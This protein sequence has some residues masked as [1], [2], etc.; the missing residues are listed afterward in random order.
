MAAQHPEV[1]PGQAGQERR[2]V[3][4]RSPAVV[5]IGDHFILIPIGCAPAETNLKE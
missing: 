1:V 5:G 3:R 4:T 2:R